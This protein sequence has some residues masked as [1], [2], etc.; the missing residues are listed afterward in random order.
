M[1]SRVLVALAVVGLSGAPA[2][3]SVIAPAEPPELALRSGCGADGKE[4]GK[5]FRLDGPLPLDHDGC[6]APDGQTLRLRA[7]RL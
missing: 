7:D 4:L 2:H 1:P 3:A 5:T 6:A